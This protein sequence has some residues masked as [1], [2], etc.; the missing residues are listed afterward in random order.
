MRESAS[1]APL[2]MI[3]TSGFGEPPS[4]PSRWARADWRALRRKP[5]RSP[6]SD[7]VE[8]DFSKRYPS[9]SGIEMVETDV[10]KL[11]ARDARTGSAFASAGRTQDISGG[12][13]DV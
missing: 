4:L 8:A 11:A 3:K 10:E 12:V 1:P 13:R 7:D 2:P 5:L 6:R 9:L